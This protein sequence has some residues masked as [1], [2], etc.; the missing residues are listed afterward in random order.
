MTEPREIFQYKK[1]D[2]LLNHYGGSIGAKVIAESFTPLAIFFFFSF[3]PNHN[4]RC[5]F[6]GKVINYDISL[7]E[8]SRTKIA[9]HN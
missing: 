8:S 1:F 2:I 7:A 9:E 5:C 3:P 6:E 4:P